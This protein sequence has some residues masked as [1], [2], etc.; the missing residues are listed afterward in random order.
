MATSSPMDP[1]K[2]VPVK[3]PEGSPLESAPLDQQA[4]SE[5]K[6]SLLAEAKDKFKM[7]LPDLVRDSL[8]PD[9]QKF[10]GRKLLPERE[11]FKQHT[12]QL[13][14][15]LKQKREHVLKRPEVKIDPSKWA[16][17]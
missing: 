15:K 16:R 14:G 10:A 7:D 5:S 13:A 8:K 2:T 4:P 11:N 9:L 1:S 17:L 12:S 6:P 3:G